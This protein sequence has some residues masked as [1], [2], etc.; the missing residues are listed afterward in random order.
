M[1][2]I[3]GFRSEPKKKGTEQLPAGPY[4][5]KIKNV[6]IDGVE[7]DQSLILRLDVSEGEHTGYFTNRYCND[8]ERYKKGDSKFAPKYKGDLRIRIP[9]PDNTK[10][11]YP[12]SDLATF[13][14]AIWCIEDSNPGYHWDWDEKTLIGLTVGFSMQKSSYNGRTFTRVAK[15]ES[16]P[17]VKMGNVAVM[18]PRE[19][20]NNASNT[21]SPDPGYVAPVARQVG[22]TEVQVPEDELPFD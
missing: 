3:N 16:A 4:I 18:E 10:A 12:E 22:F 13:N 7:P 5:G 17:E 20:R 14:D 11:M 2:Q 21:A 1:K 9:N 15:L 19:P 6:K 8:D